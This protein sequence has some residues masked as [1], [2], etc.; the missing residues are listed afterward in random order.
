MDPAGIWNNIQNVFYKRSSTCMRRA[1]D[2]T[3]AQNVPRKLIR[4]KPLSRNDTR[5]EKITNSNTESNSTYPGRCQGVSR[6]N[7][8]W[9]FR[10]FNV[11][12]IEESTVNVS[13]VFPNGH[14]RVQC[15]TIVD[16]CTAQNW[17]HL[18]HAQI[19]HKF[20]T[21]EMRA[22]YIIFSNVISK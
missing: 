9:A 2:W 6:R 15:S 7:R 1:N 14:C 10:V 8:H 12:F 22:K 19:F 11:M 18:T 17:H 3:M 21:L 5:N 16:V 20:V 13:V 4:T